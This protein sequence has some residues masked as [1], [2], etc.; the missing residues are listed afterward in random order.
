[1]NRWEKNALRALVTLYVL[2]FATFAIGRH[3]RFNS[4][5]LDLGIQDNV[6]W[7]TI[8]GRP[9][10]SAIETPHYLGDHVTLT[11]PLF[12]L[13]YL[14]REDVRI[15]LLA[16]TL[17]LAAGAF[18]L[19]WLAAKKI[20]WSGAGFA[21]AMAYLL[22][23]PLGFI[24]RFDFHPEAAVVPL[25]LFAFWCFEEKKTGWGY[26]LTLLALVSKES[27]GLVIGT[28]GLSLVV[29]DRKLWRRGLFFAVLGFG[30]SGV[31]LFHIIPY[32]RGGASDTLTRYKDLGETPGQILTTLATH[33]GQTLELLLG[34][35]ARRQYL[36]RLLW[37]L[38][39]L[40]LL[41]PRLLIVILPVL[42]YNLLSGNVSQHSI[43]Y[44]Y[45]G[46]AIP[47]LFVSAILGASAL[48]EGNRFPFNR[49]SVGLRPNLARGWFFLLPFTCLLAFVIHNPFTTRIAPPYF[50]VGGWQSVGNEAQIR[51]AAGRIPPAASLSTTMALLPH[52]SHRQN[53][54]LAWGGAALGTD[55]VLFNLYDERWNTPRSDYDRWLR[56]AREKEQ[57]R[58]I[59]FKN[60]IVLLEHPRMREDRE[61][62]LDGYFA[63]ESENRSV[64]S[65]VA[66]RVD[67]DTGALWGLLRSG[68]VFDASGGK[69]VATFDSPGGFVAFDA[70]PGGGMLALGEMGS[71]F[72]RGPVELSGDPWRL[73]RI[74]TDIEATPDG[75]GYYILDC[76]GRVHTFG[77]ARYQGDDFGREDAGAAIDL[78][79]TPDGKGYAILR[80]FGPVTTFGHLSLRDAYQP[81]GW[82]I[83]R[84]IRLTG[85]DSGYLLDGFGGIH[86]RGGAPRWVYPGY[87]PVDRLVDLAIDLEGRIW[88]MDREGNIHPAHRAGE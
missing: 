7:N 33:P 55:Y 35:V 69:R 3:N 6:L 53:I 27:Y 11:I 40:S 21:A 65:A 74:F 82:N 28:W 44:Q 18:P 86:S 70:I 71:V 25:L 20:R 87:A 81:F 61:A 41:C 63:R 79:L 60:G 64:T 8:N 59:Y 84:A 66:L 2:A 15:V 83:A 32:F 23:P 13:L 34:S 17:F 80:S 1:M 72:A 75:K 46:P 49:I 16:Q 73:Q 29:F 36:W 47:W 50:E 24:N 42:G 26:I 22:Y 14:V 67:P 37:P 52:F 62:S 39:G 58:V 77:T 9:F 48:K 78:A 30:W 85:N 31:A 88:V 38:A 51:E 10:Q 56:E 12:S 45:N 19:A 57:S 68:S 43:Y 76:F 54:Y 4:S 5:A